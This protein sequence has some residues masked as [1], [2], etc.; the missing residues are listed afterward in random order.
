MVTGVLCLVTP[1][2]MNSKNIIIIGGGISGLATLHGLKAK[3]ADRPDVKIILLEKAD[4][5][6][7]TASSQHFP[8]GIFEQGPN[9]FLDSRQ[10]TL[11]LCEEL[12]L[13]QQLVRAADAADKKFL[14][15]GGQLE[16]FPSD[17]KSFLGFR[18]LPF[19]DK[20][21]LPLEIFVR[22][23][24]DPEETVYEFGVRRFGERFTKLFLDPFVTGIY[25]GDARELNLRAAFPRLHELEQNYGSLFRALMKLRQAKRGEGRQVSVTPKGKLTSFLRGMSAVGETIAA[26]YP[27]SIYLKHE[28]HPLEASGTGFKVEAGNASFY[29]DKVFLCVPAFVAAGLVRNVSIE[30]SGLLERIPYAPMAVVGLMYERRSFS[31]PPEGFGYLVPSYEQ[32]GVIGVLFDSNMFPNRASGDKVMIR[33]ML[34]GVNNPGI[35]REDHSAIRQLAREELAERFQLKAQPLKEFCVVH[36]RA[37]PQYDRSY[38]RLLP[39]L[40]QESA[41]Q[42]NLFLVANYLKGVAFNDCVINARKAVLRCAI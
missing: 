41:R 23:G 32:K 28:V 31:H 37:I 3:F 7:G 40:E 14:L 36:P 39:A 20:I 18:P 2:L 42:E 17:L 24:S 13:K 21:R 15:L 19:W 6:G 5:L 29:A 16:E 9:G 26:K 34:G 4:H 27:D 10:E 11:N 8:E 30:F 25:G 22:K 12:G 33:L 38:A 35:V 1:K